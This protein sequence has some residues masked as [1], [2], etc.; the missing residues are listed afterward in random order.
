MSFDKGTFSYSHHG[1]LTQNSITSESSL[2]PLQWLLPPPGPDSHCPVVLCPYR[3]VFS[4]VPVSGVI[5]LLLSENLHKRLC[6]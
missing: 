6:F 5:W 4:T 1:R 3:F 2:C